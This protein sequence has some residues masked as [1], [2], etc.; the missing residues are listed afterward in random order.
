MELAFH[1]PAVVAWADIGAPIVG[2]AAIRNPWQ[3]S[4]SDLVHADALGLAHITLPFVFPR[5]DQLLPPSNDRRFSGG[6]ATGAEILS[7]CS[8]AGQPRPLQARVR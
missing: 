1:D 5:Q 6:A 8:G 7:R 4:S 3:R 2:F